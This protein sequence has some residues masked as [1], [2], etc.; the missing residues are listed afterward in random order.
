[1]PED[2]NIS[3]LI[4]PKRAIEIQSQLGLRPEGILTALQN[5]TLDVRATTNK[6]QKFKNLKIERNE[7]YT[8]T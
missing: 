4:S 7:I 3:F 1:M 6:Q 5:G 2:N 8:Q